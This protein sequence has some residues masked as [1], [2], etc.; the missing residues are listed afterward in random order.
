VVARRQDPDRACE[1]C[2]APLHRKRYKGRLE[3][4]QTFTRRRFCGRACAHRERGPRACAHCGRRLE[5]NQSRFCSQDCW[6][7][8]E[9]P[10]KPWMRTYLAAFDRYLKDGLPRDREQMRQALPAGVRIKHPP[11]KER[12]SGD[13]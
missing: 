2:G 5:R 12:S 11:T 7:A 10:L 8:D 1:R 4:F 13:A 6:L 9:F 3:D